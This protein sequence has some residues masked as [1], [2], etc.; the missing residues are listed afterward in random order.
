MYR[1]Q[2][3]TSEEARQPTQTRILNAAVTVMR[4][5]GFDRFNIQRVL[6]LA[7]V[8]RA[9]L[10]NRFGD[11]DSLIEA[12]L[13]ELFGHELR[14]SAETITGLVEAAQNQEDFRHALREL[15]AGI[16]RLPAEIRFR[17]THTLALTASR[18]NLAGTIARAQDEITDAFESLLR[19]ADARGFTRAGLDHRAVAVM[20]QAAGVGRIVDEA[21]SEPI[22]DDRWA[23]VYFDLIDRLVL[24]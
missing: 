11:V 19:A 1:R 7:D 6:E 10:Y 14:Q 16:A 3:A 21:S 20:V 8:S 12:A 17:R 4:E 22:G 9:T 5:D 13:T 2:R 24:R 18:P 23:A 15:I